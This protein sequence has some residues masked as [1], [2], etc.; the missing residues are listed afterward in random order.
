MRLI[1]YYNSGDADKS[2]PMMLVIR[3]WK[4]EQTKLGKLKATTAGFLV[5]LDTEGGIVPAFDPDRLDELKVLA[6]EIDATKISIKRLAD[7]IS[8]LD[9]ITARYNV[10]P[11]LRGIKSDLLMKK[12]F[13]ESDTV[14]VAN[15]LSQ[16]L[17]R[18]HDE[19]RAR[20]DDEYKKAVKNAD[21]SRKRHAPEIESLTKAIAEIEAVLHAD[22]G[23]GI[24][25]CTSTLKSVKEELNET[26]SNHSV[27][28]TDGITLFCRT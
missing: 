10:I 16:V 15:A 23:K 25:L 26:N 22:N 7:K 6:A 9:E 24:S 8:V 4:D 11:S 17:L 3:Q 14:R 13:L 19:K 21:A 5:P 12:R 28:S 27:F 1:D 18:V 20:Q 2:D